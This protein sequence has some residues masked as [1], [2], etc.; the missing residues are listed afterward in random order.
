MFGRCRWDP[1]CF[2]TC[3]LPLF[4]VCF[5]CYNALSFSDHTYHGLPFPPLQILMIN[6]HYILLGVS[7]PALTSPPFPPTPRS[8]ALCQPERRRCLRPGPEQPR[9]LRLVHRLGHGPPPRLDPHIRIVI[10]DDEQPSTTLAAATTSSRRRL[11][12]HVEVS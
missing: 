9:R 8:I 3:S 4:P 6:H 12:Q 2:L 1:P 5:M 10:T 11:A 7:M